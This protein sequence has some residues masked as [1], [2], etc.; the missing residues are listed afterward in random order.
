MLW[1]LFGSGVF[2]YRIKGP[3]D[4]P[5]SH[6][7]IWFI[8]QT[9]ILLPNYWSMVLIKMIGY[10]I[11]FKILEKKSAPFHFRGILNR[12]I[13]NIRERAFLQT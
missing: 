7:L 13:L 8:Y 4:I 11:S 5:F 2:L 3:S 12:K 9:A 10:Q 1:A 6:F